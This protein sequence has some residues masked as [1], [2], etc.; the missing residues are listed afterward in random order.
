LDS[1]VRGVYQFLYK[2]SDTSRA[3]KEAA[4]AYAQDWTATNNNKLPSPF[5]PL[6]AEYNRSED[7]GYIKREKMEGLIHDVC[8][9]DGKIE[10]VKASP[11]GEFARHQ[12]WIETIRVE[13]QHTDTLQEGEI[14]QE[15][16]LP[17]LQAKP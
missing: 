9:K 6:P 8:G 3:C 16:L 17:L 11:N 15:Q 1:A 2:H 5:G 4:E 12:V 10:S 13:H 7:I 14:T